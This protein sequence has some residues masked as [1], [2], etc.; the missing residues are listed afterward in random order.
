MSN[1][2]YR[3]KRITAENIIYFAITR[4]CPAD[5]PDANRNNSQGSHGGTLAGLVNIIPHEW[6]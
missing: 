5:T 6:K 2:S 1:K 3:F 4:R